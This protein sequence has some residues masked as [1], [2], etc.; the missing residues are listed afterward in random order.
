MC[1]R[2]VFLHFLSVGCGDRCLYVNTLYVCCPSQKF[3]VSE[4]LYF[5]QTRPILLEIGSFCV[6][7]TQFWNYSTLKKWFLWCVQ[8]KA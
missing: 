5:L 3:K 7:P 1:E 2:G 8:I 4:V 6:I